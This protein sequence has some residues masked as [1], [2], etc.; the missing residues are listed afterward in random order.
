[1]LKSWGV[2]SPAKVPL[3]DLVTERGKYDPGKERKL[4]AAYPIIEGYQGGV[5]LGY[6]AVFEDPLQFNQIL[7]TV[8]LSPFGDVDGWERLHADIEYRTLNWRFRFWHNDADFYDLFGPVE[9]SRK[10]DAFIVGYKKARIYDPP[11]QLD[12]FA[13]AAVYLGLE[14]LPGAQNVETSFRNLVA[15]EAGIRYTNTTKSLGAVDHEKGLRWELVGNGDYA[16]QEF[17]PRLRAG[18]DAGVPLP[19]GNSSIWVYTSAGIAGGERSSPLGSF[20]FGAFGNNYVDDREVKRYRDYDSFPGF[21]INELDGRKFAK[22]V[23]EWNLP[24]LRFAEVGTPSFYLSSARTA[25]FAGML[26]VDRAVG[27]SRTYQTLGVQVD[28]NFTVALRLP[29]AL[30]VGAASGFVNG[31]YRQTEFLASLKIL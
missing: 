28:F 12:L 2:G 10:G 25:L 14:Q 19:M 24:P 5:A 11:R 31:D 4:G 3:D 21:E 18:F 6:H 1:V 9:R 7:T 16:R 13:Q 27:R 22:A 26:G 29:M 8:S 20:Y 15:T 17:Y 23:A 30:S